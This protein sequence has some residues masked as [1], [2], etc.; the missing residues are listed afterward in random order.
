MRTSLVDHIS[1]TG[2]QLGK[3][4]LGHQAI[5]MFAPKNATNIAKGE[6]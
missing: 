2:E 5:Q 4:R 6:G 1:C 3:A